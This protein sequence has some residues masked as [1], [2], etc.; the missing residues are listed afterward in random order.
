[1]TLKIKIIAF[2]MAINVTSNAVAQKKVETFYFNAAGDTV[3]TKA[4][5]STYMLVQ[6]NGKNR[7]TIKYDSADVM[8]EEK[9]WLKDVVSTTRTDSMWWT[10]GKFREWFPSGQLKKE[11]TY[12]FYQLQDTLKT[13]YLTGVLRRQDVYEKDSLISGHCYAKDS[14]EIAYFP[15]EQMPEFEGGQKEMFQ[16]LM[17]NVKYPKDAREN[18]VEG[19]VYVGFV[20]SKTGEIED[21]KIRRGF[22]LLNEEAIRVVKLMP[23]WKAGKQD[24]ELVSV[25]YTLPIK[26]KLEGRTIFKRRR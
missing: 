16:F 7:L 5:A 2:L 15:Y 13:Y 24:G 11:G 25:S 8:L 20:V 9:Y 14:S 21:V 23:K 17:K 10:H 12:T 26:F 3:K 18:G 19:T 1:M 6:T 4:E 22:K